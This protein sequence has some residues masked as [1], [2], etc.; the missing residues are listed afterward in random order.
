MLSDKES[1]D[2]EER[3]RFT[4]IGLVAES[5]GNKEQAEK[6]TNSMLAELEL[7]GYGFYVEDRFNLHNY[8]IDDMPEDDV[9][10]I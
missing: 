3:F 4:Y 1:E 7:R 5:F 10:L 8:V 9:P 6:T 2:R